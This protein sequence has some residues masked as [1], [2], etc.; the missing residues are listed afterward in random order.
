MAPKVAKEASIKVKEKSTP[1]KVEPKVS[2]EQIAKEAASEAVNSTLQGVMPLFQEMIKQLQEGNKP[3]RQLQGQLEEAMGNQRT[4]VVKVIQ[5]NLDRRINEN[6]KFMDRLANAPRSEFAYIRIPRLY[7]KYFGSQLPVGLN[8]ST[9]QIP[10]DGRRHL[11]HKAYIPIINMKLEYED[12]KVDY[13]EQSGYED[14]EYV[15]D[16]TDV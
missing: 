2:Q 4:R 10:I 7:K 15:D 12:Q 14:I 13:M 16:I 1:K 9:I 3:N 11:V 5:K 8:G 6:K